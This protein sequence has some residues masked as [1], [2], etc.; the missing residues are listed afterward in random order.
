VPGRR[1]IPP[2]LP[3]PQ[4]VL[5]PR[6][7]GFQLRRRVVSGFQNLHQ[8]E[9]DV[10][11]LFVQRNHFL[12]AGLHEWRGTILRHEIPNHDMPD[13]FR[14]ARERGFQLQRGKAGDEE[15]QERDFHSGKQCILSAC[16][17]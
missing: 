11:Q 16:V 13:E 2:D 1:F 9:L 7:A 4:R 8:I 6:L 10:R 12:F 3:G 5:Q 17:R 14:R 15:N